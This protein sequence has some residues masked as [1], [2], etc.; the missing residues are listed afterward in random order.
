MTNS[1]VGSVGRPRVTR[2]LSRPLATAAVSVAPSRSPS[3]CLQP[4]V[5]IPNATT[6]QWSRKTLPSMQTTRRSSS[7]NG[8]VFGA[9]TGGVRVVA[10]RLIPNR[11]RREGLTKTTFRVSLVTTAAPL[12]PAAQPRATSITPRRSGAAPAS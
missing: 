4:C 5:S 6:M 3:T 11:R 2:S 1:N 7:P 10:V 9:E 12:S 8:T